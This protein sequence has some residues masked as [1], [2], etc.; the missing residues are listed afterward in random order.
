MET[1]C[2]NTKIANIAQANIG[3]RETDFTGDANLSETALKSC[4]KFYRSI[5]KCGTLRVVHSQT[6]GHVLKYFLE[7]FATDYLFDI[8]G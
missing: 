5:G 1:C 6:R 8:P 3:Q 2:Q 7:C 4:Q